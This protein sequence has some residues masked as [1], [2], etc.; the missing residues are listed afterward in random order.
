VADA[1][2]MSRQAFLR[3]QRKANGGRRLRYDEPLSPRTWLVRVLAVLAVLGALGSQAPPWGDDV[4]TWMQT[5][6]ASASPWW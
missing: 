3:A 2:D 6:T 1:A 5:H 4:R